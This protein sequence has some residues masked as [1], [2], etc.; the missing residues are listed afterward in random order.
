MAINDKTV[1][2]AIRNLKN[3]MNVVVLCLM[4]LSISEYV[5]ISD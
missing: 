3:A 5:V 1:P 2:T 4:A